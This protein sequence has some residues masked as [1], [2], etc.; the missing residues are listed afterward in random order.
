MSA[1]T[2][3][4]DMHSGRYG[5]ALRNANH[6]LAA[7]I[8]SLHDSEGRITVP[9]YMATV[10]AL[11]EQQ[12]ADA[13]ALA[14]DEAAFYAE[15]EGVPRGDRDY[16]LRER[17]TLRPTIEINGMWGGYTGPGGKT[18]LPCLATAKITMRLVPGQAPGEAAD[19]VRRHLE[20]RCPEGV[21]LTFNGIGGGSAASSLKPGHPLLVAAETVIMRTTG[22]RPVHTRLG[23]TI[24][25]T[26]IFKE[27]LG[28]DTLTFGFAKP[29][30]DVH[31]PNEFFHLSSIPEG[32][33][34]WTLLLSELARFTPSD[35]RRAA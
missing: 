6:E 14:V 26:A 23:G 3:A 9:E 22:R 11:T 13:A 31:A 4:K 18:V 34:A 29:D 32:L 7:L 1:R 28:V 27:M 12:R 16:S 20:A 33:T 10:P 30:E 17:L 24:P 2:A 5:G 8:A 15:L 21:R 19:A 35:F 25:I